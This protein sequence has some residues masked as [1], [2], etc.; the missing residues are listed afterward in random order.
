MPIRIVATRKF[1]IAYLSFFMH[2]DV[3]AAV[4]AKMKMA[5]SEPGNIPSSLQMTAV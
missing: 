3:H 5:D 4:L 2:I 1:G